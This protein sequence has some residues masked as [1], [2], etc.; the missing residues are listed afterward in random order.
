VGLNRRTTAA[1][2]I[3]TLV[4]EARAAMARLAG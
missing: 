4:G 3:E 2:L 1:E